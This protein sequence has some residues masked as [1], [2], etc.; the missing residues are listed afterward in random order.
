MELT[1]ANS[2]KGKRKS[3]P[4]DGLPPG[5]RS[6]ASAEKVQLTFFDAAMSASP[7]WSPDGQRIAFISNQGGTPKAWVIN[8]GGGTPHSLD[9][10][11]TSTTNY[12]VAWYPNP[13][14]VYRQPGL[15]NLRRL[16]VETQKEE[17][18]L[19]ADSGGFLVDRPYFSP[20]G[21]KFAI[22]WNR[23]PEAGLWIITREK[24]SEQLLLPGECFPLGW[25]SDGNSVYTM[26]DFA[27]EVLQI[28]LRES[29]HSRPVTSVPGHVL[30]GAGHKII[31]S[32]GE[33]KSDVWLIKD[34]DPEVDR[35]RQS[36]H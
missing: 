19:L 3:I 7:A 35:R 9:K 24:Y 14:I 20:D 16:N 2:S 26:K 15:H 36:D 5:M 28:R 4:R 17:S 27:P 33:V 23:D 32:V 29:R 6:I 30:I 10:T 21:K 11:N 34:F 22:F 13:E 1:N 25:S 31:V 8:A 18:F 12:R